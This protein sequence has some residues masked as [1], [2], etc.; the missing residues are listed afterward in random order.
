MTRQ[1]R[2]FLAGLLVVVP[3]AI[4]VWVLWTV[5]LWLD[6]LGVNL[7]L[8]PVWDLLGLHEKWPLTN[9]HGVGA[10]VL[11]VAVYLVGLLMRFWLFRRALG[12]MDAIFQRIPGVKTIYQSVRDLMRL[13]DTESSKSMGRVVEYRQPGSQLGVLGILTNEQP[14]GADGEDTAAVYFPFAYMIGGPVAFVPKAHLRDVDMPVEKALRLSATAHIA[15]D[16]DKKRRPDAAPPDAAPPGQ[17]GTTGQ[18]G[19]DLAGK[20]QADGNV[21]QK[22]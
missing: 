4:T 9:I 20:V 13:F 3:F 18:A 7:A 14:D 10:V 15:S 5:G 21:G 22:G 1:L 11:L 8:K 17:A 16:E 12:L 6:G 2:I 19:T